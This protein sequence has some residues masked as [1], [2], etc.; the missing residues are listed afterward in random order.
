MLEESAKSGY[1]LMTATLP[2]LTQLGLLL[3]PLLAFIL[4]GFN[5]QSGPV[6][7]MPAYFALALL[8][9]IPLL[10]FQKSSTKPLGFGLFF[11]CLLSLFF[12]WLGR[13]SFETG[14]HARAFLALYHFA[15]WYVF[16]TK[17]LAQKPKI[18]Q[19]LKFNFSNI[20]FSFNKSPKTF[21]LYVGITQ[22]ATIGL[23]LLFLKSPHRFGTQYLFGEGAWQM[24]TIWHVT[25]SFIGKTDFKPI[26]SLFWPKNKL[27]RSLS[28]DAGSFAKS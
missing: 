20:L 17:R 15:A 27:A 16:Y 4:L 18:D 21:W 12:F 7:N 3:I 8:L 5:Y 24:W 25:T 28:T 19:R 23:L 22:L 1:R 11:I 2:N 26:F 13:Q 14:V 9:P 6:I 10:I